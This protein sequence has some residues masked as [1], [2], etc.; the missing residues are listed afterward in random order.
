MPNRE[1]ILGWLVYVTLVLGALVAVVHFISW[2][3]A[4]ATLIGAAV[5]IGEIV[6]RYRDAPLSAV[7]TPGAA[8][9]V[10]LNGAAAFVAYWFVG[11]YNV[12]AAPASGADSKLLLTRTLLGGFGAMGLFRSSL[13]TVRAGDQDIAVG[14]SVFLQ[15]VLAAAD[16]AVD[17]IRAE[18]RATSVAAIMHGVSFEK[19]CK[20]LP[21]HCIALMQN[22]SDPD[23]EQIGDSVT[24]L[25]E[26]PAM[27]D[28]TKAL[29]LG[30]LLMNFVGESVLQAAV[31][32]LG[33][34]IRYAQSIEVSPT[35]V[36]L[37]AVGQTVPFTVVGKDVKG[38][39]L[40]DLV[41]VVTVNPAGIVEALDNGIIKA[42][43]VGNARIS[44]A[45][46]GRRAYCDVTVRGAAIGAA[47]VVVPRPAT[48]PRTGEPPT[49]PTA[50]AVPPADKPKG[51]DPQDG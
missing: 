37:V 11:A 19:A 14:P 44:I 28:Q 27:D 12:P 22:L 31:T 32:A 35:S 2:W 49:A 47:M 18:H 15:V 4:A 46:D 29:N 26:A 1:V 41:P 39:T 7:R 36:E 42:V 5:G 30:L 8:A 38:D 10:F 33:P 40:P 48:P 45:I 21:T 3:A 50:G 13:F 17:R 43:E 34:R 23:Q 20:G 25:V 51:G 6:S 9:Y 16:R 24:D